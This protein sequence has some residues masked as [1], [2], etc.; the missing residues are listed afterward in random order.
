MNATLPSVTTAGALAAQSSGGVQAGYGLSLTDLSGFSQAMARAQAGGGA[1][2]L[3]AQAVAAPNESMQALFKPLEYINNEA[4]SLHE[5]ANVAK[6]DSIAMTPSEVVMLTVRCQEFMF[7][8]QLTANAANRTS[9]GLQ[10]LFRQQ[11]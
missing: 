3:E 11:A 7:H 4:A 1:G 2:V 6:A 5:A 8:T 9:D 10:Q